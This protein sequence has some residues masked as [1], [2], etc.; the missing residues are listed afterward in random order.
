MRNFL[1]SL[2]LRTLEAERA[3]LDT[4]N[5]R[6]YLPGPGEIKIVM[7]PGSLEVPLEKAP[8]GHLVMV[9][10]EYERLVSQKGGVEDVSLTLHSSRPDVIQPSDSSH[11]ATSSVTPDPQCPAPA[12]SSSGRN[13]QH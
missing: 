11:S 3:I 8:S 2:G 5:R 6:L 1:G 9:I 4:G 7:P 12:A 10:D 13:F